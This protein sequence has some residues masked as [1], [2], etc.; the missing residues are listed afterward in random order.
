[1]NHPNFSQSAFIRRRLVS[2][3]APLVVTASA[4]AACS[5]S[6][7]GPQPAEHTPIPEDISAEF[8]YSLEVAEVR[9]SEMRYVDVSRGETTFVLLHGNPTSSYLWR[10]IIPHLE[11]RGR[12]IVPDLIGM[13]ASD[14]PDIAYTFRDHAEYTSAL[15][16]QLGL[17]NVILV[18]HDWGGPVG[19]HWARANADRVHGLVFFETFLGPFGGFEDHF[20]PASADPQRPGV[21]DMMNAF[22][23]GEVGD[24]T[25][26]T[27]W[28]LLVRQNVFIER[29]LPMMVATRS[30]SE[31]E[32]AAYR[33]PFK[34]ES[35]RLP[36]F[37]WPREIPAN[38]AAVGGDT[39]GH[40]SLVADVA[41][42]EASRVPKLYLF[43]TPG[44]GIVTP[45][46]H[47][48]AGAL[49]NVSVVDFGP[50]AH[51]LQEDDPHRI[52]REIVSWYD[53]NRDKEAR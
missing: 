3:L 4:L 53:A 8:P 42:L 52:G 38:G 2:K 23:S 25:P 45:V 50:G 37:M 6:S 46:Q 32:L 18:L 16:D 17:R 48:W 12:V 7:T 5:Q 34:S 44:S 39:W 10:N 15:L 51:F 28:D 36:V 24:A 31:R 1:M 47:R 40:T 22:R 30:L 43:A 41:Y 19:F 26:G 35:A 27:G 49:P 13:G 11:R 33:E 21:T 14:K 20:G 29:L 9:G